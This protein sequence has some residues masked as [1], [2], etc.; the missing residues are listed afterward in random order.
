[1]VG[2]YYHYKD[3][4][5]KCP[6]LIDD[7]VHRAAHIGTRYWL[8]RLKQVVSSY[9]QCLVSISRLICILVTLYTNAEC[10][11]VFNLLVRPIQ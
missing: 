6:Y 8:E 10:Q 2:D 9:P 1:M 3:M 11:P 5:S 7:G 4:V